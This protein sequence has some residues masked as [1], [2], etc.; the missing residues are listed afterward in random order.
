MKR[1]RHLR[2]M[3][4]ESYLYGYDDTIKLHPRELSFVKGTQKVP[5]SKRPAGVKEIRVLDDHA[6]DLQIQGKVFTFSTYKPNIL[7]VTTNEDDYYE[8]VFDGKEFI[9]R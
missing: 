7:L 6:Y 3:T 4:E 1:N 8:F 5:L 9:E 2:E